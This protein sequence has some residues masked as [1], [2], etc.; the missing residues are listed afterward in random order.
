[1]N[2]LFTKMVKNYLHLFY[3]CFNGL[4]SIP[5]ECIGFSEELQALLDFVTWLLWATLG[6]GVELQETQAALG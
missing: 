2:C 4:E 1:M 3:I 6:L 5:L